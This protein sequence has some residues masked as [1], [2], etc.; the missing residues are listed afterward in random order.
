MFMLELQLYL[1]VVEQMTPKRAAEME[2]ALGK[3]DGEDGYY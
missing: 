3:A 2:K 1:Q